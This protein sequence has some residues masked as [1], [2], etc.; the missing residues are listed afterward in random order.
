MDDGIEIA[1]PRSCL[2][3]LSGIPAS[4]KSTFAARHF[5]QSEIVS[6]DG[7]RA[8]ICDDPHNQAA[9]RDA[10]ALM[11]EIIA[12][13]MKFDR[14]CVA[15]ATHLTH[16]SRARLLSL[17]KRY[18]YPA[19]LIVFDV[20]PEECKRRDAAREGRRVGSDVIDYHAGRYVCDVHRFRDEG[21][22]EIWVLHE[23]QVERVTVVRRDGRTDAAS[24]GARPS[25]P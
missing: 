5:D 4:G 9:S 6:S 10:F 14:F 19:Y 20:P 11:Y 21:F 7:C 22:R 17:C 23:D 12:A 16:E 15:D 1:L 3:V 13:R 18:N 24:S 25:E 8:V 2:L